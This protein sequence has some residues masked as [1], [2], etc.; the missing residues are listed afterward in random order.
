M[1]WLRPEEQAAWE[2]AQATLKRIRRIRVTVRGQWMQFDD[3][4]D[5]A[6]SDLKARMRAALMDW[7]AESDRDVEITVAE[8]IVEDP[9]LGQ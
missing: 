1:S 9:A 6:M 5:T 2:A 8:V 3:P 4:D 7:A